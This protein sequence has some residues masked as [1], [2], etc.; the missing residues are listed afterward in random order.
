MY[1]KVEEY[2]LSLYILTYNMATLCLKLSDLE[3]EYQTKTYEEQV[4]I[5]NIGAVCYRGLGEVVRET[6]KNELKFND[7]VHMEILRAKIENDMLGS[8]Q[9]VNKELVESR[10]RCEV[11][12]KQLSTLKNQTQGEKEHEIQ[13]RVML[14]TMNLR[15]MLAETKNT[16]KLLEQSQEKVKLLED[17]LQKL[18]TTKT[19]HKLGK[20]GETQVHAMLQDIVGHELIPSSSVK[21]VTHVPHSADFHV[22]V[23][24][25]TGKTIKILVDSKNF[26]VPV[27]LSE[28]T[29]MYADV[30]T[31]DDA[32]GGILVSLSSDISKS[33]S[34]YIGRSTKQKPVLFLS[35]HR[36]AE[37]VK[38]DMLRWALRTIAAI[39]SEK[40]DDEQ[41]EMFARTEGF[42][43]SMLKHMTVFE[44]TIK[45][46][47]KITEDFMELYSNMVKDITHFNVGDDAPTVSG[48]CEAIKKNGIRCYKNTN[49]GKFCKIHQ[50]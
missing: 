17:Q 38:E 8:L 19:S 4:M 34:F 16:D 20:I 49:G 9:S 6:L 46:H 41:R 14:E 44:A 1:R 12:E 39:A 29:K 3:E 11:L 42:L 15:I 28:I 25:P 5:A 24:M 30:D 43:N 47:T 45:S 32:R 36:I 18:T 48:N 21:D 2:P 23:M 13:Q 31:N 33:P 26:T 50:K 27:G 37:T 7:N 10:M 35:F 40:N 22:S